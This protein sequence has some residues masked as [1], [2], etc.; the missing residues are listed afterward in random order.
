MHKV[1]IVVSC[2]V[3]CGV[4]GWLTSTFIGGAEGVILSSNL[5]MGIG[6]YLAIYWHNNR[7]P[8]R[9]NV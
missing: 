6:A 8:R 1:L 2:V 5:G 9:S 3:L 7:S 4:T